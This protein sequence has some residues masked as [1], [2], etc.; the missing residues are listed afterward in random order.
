MANTT[1]AATVFASCCSGN[2]GLVHVPAAWL[3]MT[4]I[5]HVQCGSLE[6]GSAAWQAAGTRHT[7]TQDSLN[8]RVSGSGLHPR[9][10]CSCRHPCAPRRL[11]STRFC[12]RP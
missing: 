10:C 3:P 8:A 6:G 2:G 7:T 11:T 5:L 9:Q 12:E 4:S 1:H